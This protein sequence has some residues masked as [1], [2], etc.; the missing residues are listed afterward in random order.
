MDVDKLIQ[1]IHNNP[2]I[3][4]IGTEDY[5]NKTMKL[6]SWENVG[7]VM[8]EGFGLLDEH[9]TSW[10]WEW[11]HPTTQRLPKYKQFVYYS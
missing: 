4:S 9:N 8:V 10:A 3:W 7:E 5:S 1:A 6:N 2:S 11:I